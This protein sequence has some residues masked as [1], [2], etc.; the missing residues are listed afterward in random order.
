MRSVTE[1]QGYSGP[2]IYF[3]IHE[4]QLEA[5]GS[6]SIQEA[7]SSLSLKAGI[8]DTMTFEARYPQ[9]QE[10]LTL[11]SSKERALL[12]WLSR[13]S[14]MKDAQRGKTAVYSMSVLSYIDLAEESDEFRESF[15]VTIEGAALT[16]G[17]RMASFCPLPWSYVQKPKYR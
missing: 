15:F 9:L 5:G 6:A 1:G 10:S 16:C 17:D 11:D 3:S 12:S 8:A 7:F 2:V 14:Y 4:D 13:L